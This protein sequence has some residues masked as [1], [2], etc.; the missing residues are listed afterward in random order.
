MDL[1]QIIQIIF[2]FI[3]EYKFYFIAAILYFIAYRAKG[4]MDYSA[5]GGFIGKDSYKN[6]SDN[7]KSKYK[8]PLEPYVRKW[9]YFGLIT[10]KYKEKFIYST[11]I[12]VFITDYWHKQQFIFLNLISLGTALL[13]EGIWYKMLIIFIC[14]QI[15]YGIGFNTSYER[16][17]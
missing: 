3:I 6:K 2:E 1:R 17:R 8:V 11:T 10:P 15:L 7:Y 9:Y 4:N 12:L 14:L 13:I 5:K 16:K